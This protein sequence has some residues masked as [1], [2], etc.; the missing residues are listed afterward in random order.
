[1]GIE[2]ETYDNF[3]AEYREY[4]MDR[5]GKCNAFRELVEEEVTVKIEDKT[6]HYPELL[7]FCCTQCGEKCLPMHSKEMIDGCYKNMVEENQLESKFV[8]RRYRKKFE[9]CQEQN[10]LYDHR[11]Y[12]SVPGLCYDEEHS[13][14]GFLTPVYFDRKALIY[15]IS[16]PDYEV[17]IF[18]ES[19]GHL[20]KKDPE[21]IYQFD[22]SIPFGFNSNGKLVFWLGDINYMDNQSQAIL[23]GFNVDSDHLL[24]HSQFYQSQMKCVFSEPIIESQILSNKDSFICNIKNKYN[25]DLS[26]LN[27]ECILHSKNINRPIVFTEQSVSGVINA[28]DKVLVEGFN[29]E[30]L[31]QLYEVLYTELKR[32]KQY[33][34]WQSIRLIKEVLLKFC[35]ELEN[36]VNVETLIS[37]LYILH[38]YRIYLDHLLSKDKQEETKKHIV[39][40]LN[41][42]DFSQ[43]EKIYHEEVDRLN[44]LFQYLVLLSN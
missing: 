37:P 21:G 20:D 23:K 40:T 18:S 8:S 34:K 42:G 28:F 33:K 10:F 17:D 35:E 26:H 2:F 9:Y 13:V 7:V 30:Q 6:L 5:C 43:Q 12:Y 22:W 27:E 11:D 24:T 44:K 15:F 29:V 16:V 38:D 19:Y 25:I 36:A 41:V 1:M 4:H 31:R 3:I 14:E 39:S 32:D